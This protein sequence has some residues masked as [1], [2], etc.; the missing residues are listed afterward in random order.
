MFQEAYS[1]SRRKGALKGAFAR[2]ELQESTI[3]QFKG[4]SFDNIFQH[5][6]KTCYVPKTIGALCI[7][8]IS[9]AIC[10]HLQINIDNIF[11][12][13]KG[14][15][16]AVRLLNLTPKTRA[17]GDITLKYVEIGDVLSAFHKNGYIIDPAIKDSKNGD[18]FESYLCKWQKNIK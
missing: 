3:Q 9:A 15:Q 6:Y 17:I 14:P 8:D 13:G 2:P 1:H 18:T 4:S 5:V 16:R 10:R 7:Y 12:I 11:I